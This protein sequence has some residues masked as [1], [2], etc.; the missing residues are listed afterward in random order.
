MEMNAAAGAL[1]AK[2]DKLGSA[3]EKRHPAR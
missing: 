1:F 2:K 3:K